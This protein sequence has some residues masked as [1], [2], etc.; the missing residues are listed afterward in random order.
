MGCIIH[1]HIILNCSGIIQKAGEVV[2]AFIVLVVILYI[3]Y[4]MQKRNKNG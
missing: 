2:F 4:R 1:S 3:D